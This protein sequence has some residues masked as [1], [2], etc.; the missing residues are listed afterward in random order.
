MTRFAVMTALWL[1]LPAALVACDTG[2]TTDPYTS[3]EAPDL[4]YGEVFD[5]GKYDA[6]PQLCGGI[7]GLK[8][9]K[10]K[11][12]LIKETF[13]ADA[14][15]TCV[16]KKAYSNWQKKCGLT[17]CFLYECPVGFHRLYTSK[18]CC[19]TCVPDE[20]TDDGLCLAA[21]DCEGLPHIMCLGSWSCTQ[22]QCNYSCAI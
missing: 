22:G 20:P 21:A 10:N 14:S 19:G 5:D 1:P 9:P 2:D 17:K 13:P 6:A 18:N 7:A 8:C 15:G 3:T 16:G 4:S 12:C 11:K